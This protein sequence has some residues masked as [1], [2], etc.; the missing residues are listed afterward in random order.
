MMKQIFLTILPCFISLIAFS[1]CAEKEILA[2]KILPTRPRAEQNDRIKVEPNSN[3]TFQ[4]GFSL[5]FRVN[6]LTWDSST[7]ILSN[8]LS[9]DIM[10][11]QLGYLFFDEEYTFPWD[12]HIPIDPFYWNSICLTFNKS[13]QYFN[14]T[15]NGKGIVSTGKEKK[16]VLEQFSHTSFE[17]GGSYFTGQISDF[18]IWSRPLSNDEITQYSFGCNQDF[19]EK[20]KPEVIFWPKAAISYEGNKTFAKRLLILSH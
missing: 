3:V 1:F 6:F 12:I 19:V 15:I 13:S 17:V 9:L 10:S 2:I 4:D 14:F 5:C 8:I 16:I 18:N 7:L 20:S 11:N